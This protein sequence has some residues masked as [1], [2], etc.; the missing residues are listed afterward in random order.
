MAGNHSGSPGSNL[1]W[2]RSDLAVVLTCS[3]WHWRAHAGAQRSYLKTLS[4]EAREDFDEQ[5]TKA[6]ASRRIDELQQKTGR[7]QTT[8]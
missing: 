2:D 5:L 4:E 1:A 7:G 3:A 8:H 6:E